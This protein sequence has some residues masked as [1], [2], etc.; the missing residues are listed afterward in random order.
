VRDVPGPWV[1]GW[2]A[3][4]G[5]VVIAAG[6]LLEITARAHRISAQARKITAGLDRSRDNAAPLFELKATTS[7]LGSITDGLRTVR[8][9]GA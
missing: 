1:L 2:A 6:L 4:A 9:G 5:V 3:G 8:E 7:A